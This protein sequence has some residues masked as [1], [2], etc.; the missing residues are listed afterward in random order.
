ME[1]GKKNHK[2]Y[3]KLELGDPD[4]KL[5]LVGDTACGKSK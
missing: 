2:E 3:D 1:G 5:I 4:I